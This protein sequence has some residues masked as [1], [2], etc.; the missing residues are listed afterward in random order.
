MV[1]D[2]LDMRRWLDF[3]DFARIGRTLPSSH[4]EHHQEAY[5]EER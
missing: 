4:G 3:S 2:D 1:V 5:E